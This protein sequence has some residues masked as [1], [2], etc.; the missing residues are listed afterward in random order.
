VRLS[1]A[2]T[3]QPFSSSLPPGLVA[4]LLKYCKT[5]W[6]GLVHRVSEAFP[7]KTGRG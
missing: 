4:P 2:S 1:L 3:A 7:K 6:P 5:P